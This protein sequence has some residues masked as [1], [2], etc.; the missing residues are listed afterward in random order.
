MG[1][2]RERTLEELGLGVFD[3]LVIGGGIVGSRVA[4][5][6][7]RAGLRV[8]LADAGDFG[9]ATSGPPR[10]LSTVGFATSEPAISGSCVR[11]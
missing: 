5:D 1:G 6:A 10:A 8:A 3:V 7:T 11:L 4:F 9:G 2:L